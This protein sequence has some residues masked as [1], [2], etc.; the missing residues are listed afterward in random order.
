MYLK[1]YDIAIQSYEVEWEAP[2]GLL[3]LKALQIYID[4]PVL[5]TLT[6]SDRWEAFTNILKNIARIAKAVPVTL[7]SRVTV[8]VEI[9]VLNCQKCN[10]CLEGRKSLGMFFEGVLQLSWSLSF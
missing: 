3:A 2:F 5:S 1:S 9:V 7:Y 8:N 4:P 6:M 10:Q